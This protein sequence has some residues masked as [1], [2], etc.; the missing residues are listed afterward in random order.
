M[1]NYDIIIIGA[2]LGGL[3]AG[4]KLAKEG[5]KVLLIEQHHIPGGCATNFKRVG[6]NMD[7]GLHEIGDIEEGSMQGDIF[8][9][10]KISEN[11]EFLK[12]P[13]FY[14]FTNGRIDIVI[15]DSRKEAERILIEKYPEEE[16]GIKKFFSAIMG[17]RNELNRM[18]RRGLK[19][20]LVLPFFPLLFPRIVFS[21]NKTVSQF[22]DK[23]IKNDDLKLA[24]TA[25][26]GYYHDNPKTMAYSYF[27]IAQSGYY[28][29]GY[30]IKGGSQK[31]SDYLAKFITD[32][33]GKIM[34]GHKVA[35]IITENNKA[36]GVEYHKRS[37]ADSPI[38]IFGNYIIAN[39]AVPNV[40]NDLLPK[41]LNTNAKANI[42]KME[43]AC[44]LLSIYFFF[45]KPIKEMGNKHYS[46]FVFHPEVHDW[47]DLNFHVDYKERG[48]VFVDYSQIDSQ[49]AAPGKGVGAICSVDYI[50]DWITLN[51][52]EYKTR[53]EEVAKIYIEQ[54]DKLI[55]GIKDQIEYYEVGTPKTIER[56]TLNPKGTPYGFAQIPSQASIRRVSQKSSIENLYFASAWTMP[57]GGFT[58]AMLSGWF[59]AEEIIKK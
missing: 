22:M 37:S 7:V 58:G 21:M 10:L 12:L 44:S 40:F 53:K 14:R 28:S 50:D 17:F 32:N 3:V 48:F 5:K 38:K 55:P 45:K 33:G 57:G 41:G 24:L 42:N 15:P 52:A 16:K 9:D 27:A 29:G 43:I 11:I 54:L 30:Y 59:C 39:A 2:G 26:I 8:R 4:A 1:E 51:D 20:L 31:L 19:L 36:I 23:L 18:P 46:T 13:E 6:S 49:L 25:N 35:K 56:Y 47:H 34:L